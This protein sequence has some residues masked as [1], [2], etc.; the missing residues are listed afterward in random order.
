[1]RPE[2]ILFLMVFLF[3]ST[4]QAGKTPRVHPQCNQFKAQTQDGFD[5]NSRGA[6]RQYELAMEIYEEYRDELPDGGASQAKAFNQA[7]NR[8]VAHWKAAEQYGRRV[9][10]SLCV[11]QQ[12]RTRV[13]RELKRARRMDIHLRSLYV[14]DGTPGHYFQNYR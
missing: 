6:A 2:I 11:S 13:I 5:T 3:S 10:N 9:S 1:M 14:D 8:F 7:R 12:T 4:V